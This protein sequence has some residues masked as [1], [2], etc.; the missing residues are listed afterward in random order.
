M[1]HRPT[2]GRMWPA[3]CRV[4]VYFL[5][6]QKQPVLRLASAR[7]ASSPRGAGADREAAAGRAAPSEARRLLLAPPPDS[8]LRLCERT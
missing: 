8:L 6:K 2:A 1:K 7:M 3:M 4:H 5:R